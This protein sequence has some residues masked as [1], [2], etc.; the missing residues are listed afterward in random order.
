MAA[1][2]LSQIMVRRNCYEPMLKMVN[3]WLSWAII[4]GKIGSMLKLTRLVLILFCIFLA[5]IPARIL[6][7]FPRNNNSFGVFSIILWL[8][9]QYSLGGNVPELTFVLFM[10]MLRKILNIYSFIVRGADVFGL[11][12][13][14]EAS[15]TLLVSLISMSGGY[16]C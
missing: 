3:T 11:A 4:V 1:K 10:T 6:K 14:W 2:F 16:G 15:L 5:G 9:M 7:L 12:V 8:L 13:V